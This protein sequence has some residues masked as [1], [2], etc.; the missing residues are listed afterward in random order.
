MFQKRKHT[1]K[2]KYQWWYESNKL[3]ESTCLPL[4]AFLVT[5]KENVNLACR[6]IKKRPNSRQPVFRL[7][8][9][10][11]PSTWKWPVWEAKF[12]QKTIPA[13]TQT[14]TFTES[15]DRDTDRLVASLNLEEIIKNYNTWKHLTVGKLISSVTFF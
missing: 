10:L 9:P 7:E 6:S 13:E 12:T 2:V 11:A 15:M 5:H 14:P 4:F 1:T 8:V 3:K